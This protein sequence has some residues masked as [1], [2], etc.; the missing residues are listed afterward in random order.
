MK[1]WRRGPGS[2]R[3]IKVLQTS[4]LPLGYRA[5]ARQPI[6][7][8]RNQIAV[9]NPGYAPEGDLERETGLEPA[10]LALARRCSTTELLPHAASLSI[11]RS[12]KAGQTLAEAAFALLL[13]APAPASIRTISPSRTCRIRV[14][15]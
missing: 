14:A 7:W 3:R 1:S 11:P 6:D 10:T 8:S 15:I 13:A 2:N 12:W 5:L 9:A 4:P